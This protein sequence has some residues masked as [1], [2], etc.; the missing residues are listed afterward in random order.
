MVTCGE[1]EAYNGRNDTLTNPVVIFE[2]LSEGTDN[3][4]GGEKFE[5]Y[6]RLPSL[7]EY[8]ILAQDRFLIEHHASYMTGSVLQLA[9]G[10][11]FETIVS[12]HLL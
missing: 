1:P 3:Y 11:F 10:R 5:Q 6:R 7:Q 4:D 8:V 9:S 2:V 12:G